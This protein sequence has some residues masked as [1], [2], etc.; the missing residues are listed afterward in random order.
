MDVE[1]EA[2]G[3][4]AGGALVDEVVETS[5]GQPA[6]V[7]GGS[8]DVETTVVVELADAELV[9]PTAAQAVAGDVVFGTAERMMVAVEVVHCCHE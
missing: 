4:A 3:K 9:E 1:L 6:V 5:A 2:E 7:H 8:S